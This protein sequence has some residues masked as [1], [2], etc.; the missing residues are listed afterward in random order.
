[1]MRISIG[2]CF[3]MLS[4][5][6]AGLPARFATPDEEPCPRQQDD[7]DSQLDG[8]KEQEWLHTKLEGKLRRQIQDM[9]QPGCTEKINDCITQH[10]CQGHQ[11][12]GAIP[13]T[14][15]QEADEHCSGD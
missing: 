6:V 14:L 15:S 5:C 7:R 11:P 3:P 9:R 8:I 12:G 13:A 10:H 2:A 1:M 4:L